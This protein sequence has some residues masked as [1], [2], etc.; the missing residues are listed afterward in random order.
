MTITSKTYLFV[1]VL[2]NGI[3][4]ASVKKPLNYKSTIT[5]G[6]SPKSDLY[7]P[8]YPIASTMQI[9]TI[10]KNKVFLEWL[11]IWQGFL[12]NKGKSVIISQENPQY[13]L[14]SLEVND[15]GCI[16]FRDLQILF[17]IQTEK[18]KPQIKIDPTYK[19]TFL[20]FIFETPQELKI[21]FISVLITIGCLIT[22]LSLILGAQYKSPSSLTEINQKY[23]LYFIHPNHFR[24]IP[25]ALKFNLNRKNYPVSIINFYE[26]FINL[27]TGDM[28]SKSKFFYSQTID[29]YKKLHSQKITN[30]QN[31]LLEQQTIQNAFLKKPYTT[32]VSIPTV[33]GENLQSTLYR[34]NDKISILHKSYILSLIKRRQMITDF[35]KDSFYNYEEYKNLEQ[36][37]S[38]EKFLSQI[39]PFHLMTDE[40]TMYAT[41]ERLAQKSDFLQKSI[42]QN[43]K[44]HDHKPVIISIP[45]AITFA[46]FTPSRNIKLSEEKINNIVAAEFG[47]TQAQPKIKEPL[48]GEL[49]PALI[50]KVIK[51]RKIDLQLCYEIAL[52][53][54]KF[55][56]GKT[57][58][59][60]IINT[61]GKTNQIQLINTT[62]NDDNMLK[63][64]KDKISNWVFPKPHR[65]SLVIQY[66]FVF[67]SEKG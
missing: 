62:I 16:S 8:L 21:F 52:R 1:E 11:S 56:E 39:T 50:E 53:K 58:W 57:E 32:I 22:L 7:I 30:L 46:S 48:V 41:A 14:Y 65:G 33:K 60:W 17:K 45:H 4:I 37:K 49:Q 24:T 15:Y 5:L 66:P 9:F 34:I 18:V 42:K 63:C 26:D 55:L 59:S 10:K 12:V 27:H 43:I 54:N 20:K 67:K 29:M 6:T 23:L 36:K 25:E 47:K 64:I 38:T 13:E 31:K 51:Q 3:S 35:S 19:D 44:K 2:Q 40:V 61:N 28:V